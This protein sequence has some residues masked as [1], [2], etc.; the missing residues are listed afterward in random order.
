[1]NIEYK[2]RLRFAIVSLNDNFYATLLCFIFEI[3]VA[4][5]ATLRG[6]VV[7]GIVPR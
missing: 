2:Q 5:A 3:V 6:V 4:V 1:M 7:D